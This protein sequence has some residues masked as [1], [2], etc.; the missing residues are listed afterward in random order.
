MFI[1]KPRLGD[2]LRKWMLWNSEIG[3]AP[4]AVALTT[5]VCE[6]Y[7]V[8]FSG[9]LKIA[10]EEVTEKNNPNPT[11]ELIRQEHINAHIADNFSALVKR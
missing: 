8:Y 1:N 10:F 2:C 7:V 6:R 9:A 4:S 5:G 3:E 11:Y